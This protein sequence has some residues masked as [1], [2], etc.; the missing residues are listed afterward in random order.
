M[1]VHVQRTPE[2]A[3]PNNLQGFGHNSE[4][5]AWHATISPLR[6]SSQISDVLQACYLRDDPADWSFQSFPAQNMVVPIGDV[7]DGKALVFV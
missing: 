1:E 7:T 5:K 2:V 6:L 4:N 3:S